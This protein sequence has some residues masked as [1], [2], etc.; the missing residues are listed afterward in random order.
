MAT[1]RT[2][3]VKEKLRD[4]EATIEQG[5]PLLEQT[6]LRKCGSYHNQCLRMARL[7]GRGLQM[8]GYQT[9]IQAGSASWPLRSPADGERLEDMPHLTYQWELKPSTFDIVRCQ[10]MPEM[11]VWLALVEDGQGVAII[12]PTTAYIEWQSQELNGLSLQRK[13]PRCFVGDV[14]DMERWGFAYIPDKDA[15][16]LAVAM[17]RGRSYVVEWLER[18]GAQ[19]AL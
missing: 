19:N 4:I 12:D 15:C 18:R 11:H 2:Q 5:R 1:P 13:T 17:L 6:L 16:E 14:Q 7:V 10:R 9:I 8:V 3:S